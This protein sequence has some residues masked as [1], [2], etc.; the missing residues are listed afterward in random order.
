MSDKARD[1]LSKMIEYDPSKR[2][3]VNDALNHPFFVEDLSFTK[4]Y[5]KILEEYNEKNDLNS[6]ESIHKNKKIGE[7]I[8][9]KYVKE[10]YYNVN[11]KIDLIKYYN[12]EVKNFKY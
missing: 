9:K 3:N 6:I 1:L 8:H 12:Q 2:I 7:V 4:K 11:N 5:D 10:N